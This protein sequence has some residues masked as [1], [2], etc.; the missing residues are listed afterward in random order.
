MDL[1]HL[2][3]A[4]EPVI[5]LGFLL[6]VFA[7]IGA[8]EVA[9][10]RR[11]STTPKA[12]RWIGNLGLVALN[13]LLLRLVFPLAAAG[14]VTATRA[15]SPDWTACWRCPSEARS[16]AMRSIAGAGAMS[17]PSDESDPDA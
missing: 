13:T 15:R 5:R 3:L 16:T 10:P 1:E 11:A 14:T 6:V 12:M 4:N 2:V 9:A 17:T 7:L 8:W